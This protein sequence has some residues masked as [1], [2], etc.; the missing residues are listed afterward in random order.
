[1]LRFG[2]VPGR[3]ALLRDDLPIQAK[4]SHRFEEER[5]AAAENLAM[6]VHVGTPKPRRDR[7]IS[8]LLHFDDAGV[9]VFFVPAAPLFDVVD[10]D[11]SAPVRRKDV[12]VAHLPIMIGVIVLHMTQEEMQQVGDWW[13]QHTPQE[14]TRA[15][16]GEQ[17]TKTG[18]PKKRPSV[19]LSAWKKW[20]ALCEEQRAYIVVGFR[21]HGPFFPVV[22][23]PPLLELQ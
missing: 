9:L 23:L 14:R 6:D 21:K 8:D 17:R 5:R 19:S 2:F 13:D 16:C 12:Q 7:V 4:E 15:W 11:R 3:A 20:E 1:M 22:V 10:R 18:A